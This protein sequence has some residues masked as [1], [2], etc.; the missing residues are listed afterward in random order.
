MNNIERGLEWITTFLN[1]NITDRAEY[2]DFCGTG[3]LTEEERTELYAGMDSNINMMKAI[4][5]AVE[6]QISKKVYHF[7][8]DDT[9]ETTCCGTDISNEDYNYCPVCGQLLGEVEEVPEE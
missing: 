5:S 9:F 3:D 1:Y 2:E 7:N 4:K 8:E 6:K